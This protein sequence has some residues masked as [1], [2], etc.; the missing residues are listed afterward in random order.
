M[1]APLQE[2]E[3]P[4][5]ATEIVAEVLTEKHRASTFLMNVGL[6]SSSS[7]TKFIYD[8]VVA[9][10][11]TD[12]KQQLERSEDQGQAMREE[13]AELKKKSEESEASQ[14]ARDKEYEL[15]FARLAMMM[16]GGTT[17]GN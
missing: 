2:G 5:S 14:L 8:A 17:P 12:L 3:E 7:R 1:A 15:R 16:A 4:K 9:A 11:V 13:L 10:Q 6:Q